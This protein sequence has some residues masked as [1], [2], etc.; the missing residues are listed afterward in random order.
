MNQIHQSIKAA[1]IIE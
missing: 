1:K